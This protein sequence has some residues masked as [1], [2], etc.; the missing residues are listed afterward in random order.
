L[1]QAPQLWESLPAKLTHLP[2][3]LV[4]PASQQIPLAQYPLKHSIAS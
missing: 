1:E 3:Q 2:L 4:N